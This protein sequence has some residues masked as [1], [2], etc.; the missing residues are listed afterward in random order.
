MMKMNELQKQLPEMLTGEELRNRIQ[1]L[2]EY[3]DNFQDMSA[4]ERLTLLN[5]LYNIYVPSAMSNEIYTKLYLA[6][7][8]SLG[9][10]NTIE[11]TQQY[12]QNYRAIKQQEHHG[13]IGGSDS[14]TIIGGAGIGKSSAIFRAITLISQ[15]IIEIEKPYV[16]IV[17]CIVVQCP[18]DSSVKSLL[19]EILRKIDEAIESNYHEKA[20]KARATTDMLIGSVSQTCLNHVGLLIIDEIQNV[21]NSKNGK[22]LIGSLTQLINNS[23]IS[24]CMVGTPDCKPFLEQTAYLARR[25]LGL[26]YG[27]MKYDK[28]FIDFCT[29]IWSY[30]YVQ[31]K[32]ELTPVIL[33]WLYEHSG[34]NTSI[35][36]ALIHDSQEIAI[37]NGSETLNIENLNKA[38]QQRLSMLHDY[39]QPSIVHN[40]QTTKVKK[41]KPSKELAKTA[42]QKSDF[43]ITDLASK[44]KSEG[45]DFLSL[46]R[47]N[48]IVEEITI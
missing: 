41:S 18:F 9:K 21:A 22:N 35:I 19:L 37:L 40:S 2:P 28:H 42:P 24:I 11:T 44:A 12:Y 17:P 1:V 7:L 23:G 31:K 46:L 47:E 6:T 4:T 38:Y 20:V 5:E 14:F 33:E 8:R 39:I 13:I 29:T 10:K 15:G 36:V 3:N 30:Q 26:E 43:K 16:K 25:S 34:G 45:L 32:S 27:S 48:L